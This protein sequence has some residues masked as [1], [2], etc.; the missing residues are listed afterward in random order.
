MFRLISRKAFFA[1]DLLFALAKEIVVPVLQLFHCIL[2]SLASYFLEPRQL[3]LEFGYFYGI[4]IVI[5]C[6]LAF[7]VGSDSL[8]EEIVVEVAN[9]TEV[10]IQQYFLLWSW[11]ESV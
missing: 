6:L 2:Q 9:T 3:F 7:F 11:I 5:L 4:I 1:F 10:L 8:S